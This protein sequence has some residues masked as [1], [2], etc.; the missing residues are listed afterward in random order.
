MKKL[1]IRRAC[2][3]LLAALL[4][5]ACLLPARSYA[6]QDA[7]VIHIGSEAELAELAARC[8]LDTWSR[9]R[10]VVLDCDLTLS[11]GSF[12]PIPSFG[13]VFDG[14]GHAI[15]GIRVSGSLSPAGLFGV[16]QAGG[17]VRDLRAE[18]AVTPEGDARSAGGIAGENRG[19]IENC[20]F[21]GTVS[22][23]SSIGGIAGANMAAGSIL[24][25]QAAGAAAGEVMT[26]GI[27]GYN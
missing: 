2:G 21:T 22:G 17:V 18:G 6:V 3:A 16:V 27:A 19:T 15:R 1:D 25:C 8:A 4:L 23:K 26:G 5:T 7:E 9:G 14:Q 10:T 12:L 13:G 11:D 20:S 24:S